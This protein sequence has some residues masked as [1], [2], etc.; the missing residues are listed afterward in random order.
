MHLIGVF[1][2]LIWESAIW[3]YFSHLWKE[4]IY[5]PKSWIW[6][7]FQVPKM[8]FLFDASLI[9]KTLKR[10]DCMSTSGKMA[11]LRTQIWTLETWY[12]LQKIH[13][14]FNL[15]RQYVCVYIYIHMI[16]YLKIC[17]FPRGPASLRNPGCWWLK[18]LVPWEEHF[19]GSLFSTHKKVVTQALMNQFVCVY[20]YI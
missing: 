3:H 17:S 5:N 16:T 14:G 11:K 7:P 10:S 18:I 13:Q 1:H 12:L 9:C 2:V 15:N 4:V 20:I 6:F 8:V 19:G